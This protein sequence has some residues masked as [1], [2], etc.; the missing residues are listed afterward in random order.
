M[1]QFLETDFH[2]GTLPFHLQAAPPSTCN[3]WMVGS[4]VY[5]DLLSGLKIVDLPI[6]NSGFTVIYSDSEWIYYEVDWKS[7]GLND[8]IAIENADYDV[9]WTGFS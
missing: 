2:Q 4:A 5:G 9:W 6:E 1:A 8:T 3:G 7:D